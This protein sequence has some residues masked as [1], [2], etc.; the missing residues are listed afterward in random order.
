[1]TVLFGCTE[2]HAMASNIYYVHVHRLET[3]VASCHYIGGVPWSQLLSHNQLHIIACAQSQMLHA[4][5][6]GPG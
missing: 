6:A 4:S 3:I 5:V 2:E 1:M